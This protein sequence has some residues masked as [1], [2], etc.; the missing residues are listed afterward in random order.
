MRRHYE[1]RQPWLRG[2]AC[3]GFLLNRSSSVKF[4]RYSVRTQRVQQVELFGT[5]RRGAPI[6][7]IDDGTLAGAFD[8]G[9]RFLDKTLQPLR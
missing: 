1:V 3:S 5:R 8:R 4:A 2:N 7:Q 9:V 6:R